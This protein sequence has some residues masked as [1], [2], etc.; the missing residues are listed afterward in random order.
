MSSQAEL[1]EFM[2]DTQSV[3][4]VAATLIASLTSAAT[5]DRG[6]T[7]M[8]IVPL[9]TSTHVKRRFQL[10]VD[11]LGKRAGSYT[12]IESL[13]RKTIKVTSFEKGEFVVDNEFV[14]LGKVQNVWIIRGA[15]TK[16]MGGKDTIQPAII[17]L[18]PLPRNA[19]G[20]PEIFTAGLCTH[21]LKMKR[22]DYDVIWEEIGVE[23]VISGEGDTGM[24]GNVPPPPDQPPPLPRL[25]T[26]KD[27]DEEE[28]LRQSRWKLEYEL[29]RAV[30]ES[31]WHEEMA[32][33]TPTTFLNHPQYVPYAQLQVLQNRVELLEE[34]QQ[35]LQSIIGKL[36]GW[37]YSKLEANA[38][39]MREARKKIEALVSDHTRSNTTQVEREGGTP[40]PVEPISP[41]EK[42]W[43]KAYRDMNYTWGSRLDTVPEESV[44]QTEPREY[45]P[46]QPM[47]NLWRDIA[48]S[49]Q[50][51]YLKRHRSHSTASTASGSNGEH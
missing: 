38:Y 35:G 13:D 47:A 51:A 44:F 6:I 21:S 8:E 24:N 14:K 37:E 32:D 3:S 17:E 41:T 22:A 15:L 30:G 7:R 40:I 42:A 31:G 20:K 12:E 10:T 33:P 46:P 5:T 50:K 11:K 45:D 16:L 23:L 48:V 34:K 39:M 43:E 19:H 26:E 4:H 2:G 36:C 18:C 29:R 25:P 49:Q 28:R 1:M 27:L 9:P